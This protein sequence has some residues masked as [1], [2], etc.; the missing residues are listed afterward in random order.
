MSKTYYLIS[1][2]IFES[3][4]WKEN[5]HTLKLFL[6]LIGAARY[7]KKPK[8]YPDVTLKR[9]EYLGSLAQ[10]AEDNEYFK[11][12]HYKKW[13]RQKVSR[14]LKKL[15]DKNHIKIISD[16]YGTHIRVTNYESYQNPAGYKR[17]DMEQ[18]WN[19]C[20]TGVDITEES[21]KKG[22][23]DP[24]FKEL[25]PIS[26]NGLFDHV[27][28]DWIQHRKEM[29]KPVK[30]TSA[31]QQIKLLEGLGQDRA[32]ETVRR[33]IQNGWQGLFPENKEQDWQDRDA[34]AL[35]RVKAESE[36]YDDE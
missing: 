14:M 33:S 17:T 15:Q 27:W 26:F 8:K 36:A 4:I 19:G 16:T 2:E 1:R 29:G 10:I 30:L 3:S 18:D 22:N 13:S 5:P 23:K 11:H 28:M 32:I 9:G 6:Y 35:R 24:F 20:G 25:I 21:S 7:G 31:K 12:G 34:E